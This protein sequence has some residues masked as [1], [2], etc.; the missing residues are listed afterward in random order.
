MSELFKSLAPQKLVQLSLAA[1]DNLSLHGVGMFGQQSQAQLGI[2]AMTPA[3]VLSAE[4]ISQGVVQ[5]GLDGMCPLPFLQ[6]SGQLAFMPQGLAGGMM[7]SVLMTPLGP[8]V[9][10]A[11][12]NG[13]LSAEWIV[14]AG[15]SE[16]AQLM[17]GA[18]AWGMPGLLG[19]VKAA[20][21]LQHYHVK[22]EKLV[23]SSTLNLTVTAPKF[24]DGVAAEVAPSW[25][26]SIFH[27]MSPEHNLCAA[28]DAVPA[29]KTY[30]LSMGGTRK[31]SDTTRLRGRLTTQS[32]I[33]VALEVCGSPDTPLVGE[34]A[35]LNLCCEANMAPSR[36]LDPKLGATLQLSSERSRP[37]HG[38]V[39]SLSSSRRTHAG[40]G[41]A[42]P[43]GV[44]CI[45]ALNVSCSSWRPGLRCTRVGFRH[46]RFWTPHANAMGLRLR[47]ARVEL[48]HED[49]A[50][51]ACDT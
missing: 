32:V 27:R 17:L 4:L 33:S 29:E 47:L 8:V 49:T 44:P 19:G 26:A 16:S 36:P 12:L 28:F 42:P 5:L 43:R 3:G 18:H 35:V 50:A 15:V 45:T 31:L 51:R 34:K 37:S 7:Q 6:L 40:G 41:L 9:T 25:S 38:S 22:D 39:T 2:N 13:M 1:R 14:G 46:E 20:A 30:V 24:V 10:T 23:S 21:E 48:Y 11:G